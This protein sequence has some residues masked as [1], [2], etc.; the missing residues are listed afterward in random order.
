ML[1]TLHKKLNL[2]LKQKSFEASLTF[3]MNIKR[4]SAIRI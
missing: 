3:L 4:K 1:Q 2:A